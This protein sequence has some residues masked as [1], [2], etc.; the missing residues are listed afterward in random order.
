MNLEYIVPWFDFT[1]F[2][3]AKNDVGQTG[4]I[5]EAYVQVER[6]HVSRQLSVSSDS[7]HTSP[8]LTKSGLPYSSSASLTDYEVQAAMSAEAMNHSGQIVGEWINQLQSRL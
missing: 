6:Q 1:F 4:Y 3:Q 5:P 2:F 8:R 7:S